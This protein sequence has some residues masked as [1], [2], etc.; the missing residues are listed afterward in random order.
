[1]LI[2]V[3]VLGFLA[4]SIGG[5]EEVQ[6]K[7]ER[8]LVAEIP[9]KKKTEE[10]KTLASA[11][12]QIQ[13][14]SESNNSTIASTKESLVSQPV[15][16][17]VEAVQKEKQEKE[18]EEQAVIKT[19]LPSTEENTETG[20]KEPTSTPEPSP[21]PPLPSPQSAPVN[22]SFE[23]IIISEIQL[24]GGT[25]KTQNDFIEL[26]NPNDAP[27]D[28]SGWKLRKRTKSGNES[29]IRSLPDG[30]VIPTHG[31][32]LWANSN[33]DYATSISADVESTTSIADNTSIALVDTNGT[34]IDAIA[35]GSDLMNPFGEGAPITAELEA[36]Q[37]YTRNL[38]SCPGA[39]DT[40]NNNADFTVQSVAT[41]KQ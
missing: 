17:E 26:Y 30:S 9:V 14:K 18:R 13:I 27:V 15:V 24:T 34:V 29:S 3:V 10:E 40:D 39:C 7:S 28:I 19:P 11:T 33:D 31:F 23:K 32:F 1:M 20:S 36:N 2:G 22:S 12:E 41:P 4:M 5:T 21:N 38:A 35:W 16:K 25:G 8:K 6:E 37:S